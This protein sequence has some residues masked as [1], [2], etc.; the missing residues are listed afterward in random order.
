M[1]RGL[2]IFPCP[3]QIQIWKFLGGQS[4]FHVQAKSE[5]KIF[6]WGWGV[7]HLS[8][9]RLSLKFKI[10]GEGGEGGWSSFHVQAKSKF[11]IFWGSVIF[12]RPRPNL[13]FEIFSEGG[14][15]GLTKQKSKKCWK[16]TYTILVVGGG[17]WVNKTKVQKCWKWTC[18]ILVGR[19][20]NET[21]SKSAR[22][23]T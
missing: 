12:P 5:I 9:S 16:W 2:D 1:G 13:K 11:E 20:V 15:W 3:G 6:W 19:G 7:G 23:W 8:M 22:K 10:I 18:T 4:S 21:K 17:G 14:G